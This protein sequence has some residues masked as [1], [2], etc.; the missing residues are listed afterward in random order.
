MSSGEQS[1]DVGTRLT[2]VEGRLTTV[3]DEVSG[4]KEKVETVEQQVNGLPELFAQ[5]ID[6]RN[7]FHLKNVGR[8]LWKT[9]AG[10]GLVGLGAAVNEFV[11]AW[12]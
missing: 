5:I 10:L 4:L 12:L 6:D 9:I 8:K 3:E 2:R 1:L 7:L 11:K